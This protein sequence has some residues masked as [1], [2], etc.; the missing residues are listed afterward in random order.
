MNAELAQV[1][2]AMILFLISLALTV[3]C[4]WAARKLTPW[5][6]G[7]GADTPTVRS[8]FLDP[9]AETDMTRER[10]VTLMIAAALM[11]GVLLA[12]ACVVRF[13]GVALL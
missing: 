4:L 5:F 9:A 2:P 12:M 6:I 10:F 3:V 7:K 8:Y 11:L 13:G 1:G